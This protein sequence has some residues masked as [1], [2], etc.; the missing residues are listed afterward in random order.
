MLHDGRVPS[1][2]ALR[3]ARLWARVRLLWNRH[4][5]ALRFAAYVF[6]ASGRYGAALDF[7][8]E[9]FERVRLGGLESPQAQE[10]AMG[11]S[12]VATLACAGL[13]NRTADEAQRILLADNALQWGGQLAKMN[14][15]VF[16]EEVLPSAMLRD[17]RPFLEAIA[18]EAENPPQVRCTTDC[19]RAA[20]TQGSAHP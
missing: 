8:E 15:A 6:L 9:A 11:V 16:R 2:P 13:R 1:Y 5:S 18:A 10:L 12:I 20:R 4:P 19:A 3:G 7:A 14:L 17:L